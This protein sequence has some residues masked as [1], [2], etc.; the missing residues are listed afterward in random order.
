MSVY[1]DVARYIEIAKIC[2][3]LYAT[4]IATQQ[5]YKR[6]TLNR[7]YAQLLYLVRKPIEYKFSVD[8]TNSTLNSTAIYMIGLCGKLRPI[9]ES[10]IDAVPC[11]APVILTNPVTQTIDEGDPVTFFI[12]AYGTSLTYQW[13]KDGSNI[14]GETGTSYAI[15]TVTTG[16]AGSYRCIVTNGCGMAT[17]TAAT[18]TV[19]STALSFT[20]GWSASD[21]FVDESTPLTITN[22]QSVSFVS[23]ANLIFSGDLT[24][25]SNNYVMWS[26]PV[27]EPTPTLWSNG[28]P[29]IVIN[30]GPIPDAT[31]R[32]VWTVGALKYTCSRIQMT[33]NP[34]LG[35]RL[36][37]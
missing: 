26:W 36:N 2:Q 28:D 34:T 30:Q 14:V 25:F 32:A 6:S 21:P 11:I 33:L 20:I 1:V 16:D 4:E 7:N 24:A 23:G 9:A 29:A 31:V 17:S 12:T 37:H 3:Y 8:P 5:F 27:G 10:I 35:L 22:S 19:T 15:A 13:Q 18:L